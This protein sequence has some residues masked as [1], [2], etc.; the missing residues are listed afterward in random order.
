M[1]VAIDNNVLV[2]WATDR[3]VYVNLETFLKQ[4]N[5]TLLIPTPVIAE[6]LAKDH[7]KRRTKF[8]Q[9][10]HNKV[11]IGDFD[12]KAAF[13]CGEFASNYAKGDKDKNQKVKVDLQILS[14]AIANEAVSILTE[15]VDIQKYINALAITEIKVL[16]KS[17]LK[18]GLDLFDNT[19]V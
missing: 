13:I 18:L 19:S 12:K 17:D 1:I 14:I 6:F 8:M 16:T 2:S 5:A 4:S 15:D 9:I 11:L 10:E 7:N 3:D